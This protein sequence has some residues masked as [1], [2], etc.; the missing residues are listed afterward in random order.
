MKQEPTSGPTGANRSA[1]VLT[2]RDFV[3][4][5]A[6]AGAAWPLGRRAEAAV[7]AGGAPVIHFFSKP[8]YKMSYRDTAAFVAECGFGG[9]DYT[10]REAQGHVLP[11]RVA[12]DLPRAVEAA[13]AAGLKVE[14]ITTDIT[15]PRGPHTEKVLR[16]AAGQGVKVY[17]LGNF[18]Y[19][20]KLGVWQTLEKLKPALKELA[21]LNQ[22]LGIHG[23]I[24]NHA[25]TRV[26]GALWDLYELVRE[27]DPRWLGVQYDIRH[28]VVE[29]A[30]SW[31]VTLRLLSPWIRCLDLKDFKWQQ[32]PGK[33]SIENVPLGEGV[34]PLDAYFKLVREL[35]V[36][37][38][39]SLHFEY[40]PFERATGTPTEEE[41]RASFAAAMRKDLQV[42]QQFLAKY[43]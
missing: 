13:R 33:A 4:R 36:S 8:L 22:S 3:A 37:G 10:V 24:Q 5:V 7:N 17:R 27:A 39:I 9:I 31:P 40:P 23:A 30:Q 2:R 19:D 38:P 26:G 18:N 28:A 43:R 32:A 25:G 6:L 35:K 12:E 29:G 1:A 20:L 42:L 34:V 15:D 16:A 21:A 41:K 14:M 11:E